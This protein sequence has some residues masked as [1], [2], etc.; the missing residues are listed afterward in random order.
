MKK[1]LA[2]ILAFICITSPFFSYGAFDSAVEKSQNEKSKQDEKPK[3]SNS[4]KESSSSASSADSAEASLVEFFFELFAYVWLINFYARYYPYPYSY[5]DTKYLSY[6]DLMSDDFE[7]DLQTATTPL[8]FYRFSLDTSFV[9]LKELG[10]GNESNFDCMIFPVIGLY[11]KNLILFD[12]IHGEGNMGNIQAG[13]NFPVFQTNPLSLYLKFGWS[14]WYND[15]TPLLRDNA[16]VFGGE[17][18]S[19]PFKP[20]TLRWKF[21]WQFYD[22]DLYVFD[23]DLLAGVMLD[24]YEIFAGWKYLETGTQKSDSTEWNGLNCGIR[25]HF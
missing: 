1:I 19:F 10:I 13:I 11:A 22:N 15:I 20:V 8:R 5:D 23:S 12:H 17:V 18:K 24:R 7:S 16:F 2:V 14:R 4:K 25:I 3:E 6:K 21:D 9:W